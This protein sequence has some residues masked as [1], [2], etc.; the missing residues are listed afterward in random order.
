MAASQSATK[1]LEDSLLQIEKKTATALESLGIM[2]PFGQS[3]EIVSDSSESSEVEIQQSKQERKRVKR[4]VHRQKLRRNGPNVK[5]TQRKSFS[6]PTWK[7]EPYCPSSFSDSSSEGS[8]Y[9]PDVDSLNLTQNEAEHTSSHCAD[10]V[11]TVIGAPVNKADST[12]QRECD[13][14]KVPKQH[15]VAGNS[16]EAFA[17]YVIEALGRIRI[18]P[19]INLAT[20]PVNCFLKRE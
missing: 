10:N 1:L 2:P 4:R 6:V 11:R 8:Q 20:K 12:K 9:P 13:G 3:S 15:T 16:G 5:K 18:A 7:G 19:T 14:H 17:N